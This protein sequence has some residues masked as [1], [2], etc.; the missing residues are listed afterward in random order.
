MT[1]IET[2][3]SLNGILGYFG[4][5]GIFATIFL[6]IDMHGKRTLALYIGTWGLYLA[7]IATIAGTALALVYSEVFGFIPCGLCWS[8]RVML[9]PQVVLTGV[10]LYVKDKTM[11]IYGI[12]LSAIGIL[13]ALYQH[14]LQMGGNALLPC[15]A[16][17]GDCTKRFFFEFGFPTFPLMA[18]I[19]FS[20]L[21]ALYVYI[22][23]EPSS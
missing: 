10:A 8:I 2:I 19:L 16:S 21:I 6:V 4:I 11:P 18:V 3:A 13:I 23:R 17:G 14:Y 22:Q 9:F 5:L 1:T 12:W 15:P 20:F 7:F